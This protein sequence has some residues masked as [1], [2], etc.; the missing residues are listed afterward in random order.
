MQVLNTSTIYI[1]S[2]VCCHVRNSITEVNL[3]TTVYPMMNQFLPVNSDTN[4]TFNCSVQSHLAIV[5]SVNGTQISHDDQFVN[6]MNLGYAIEPMNTESSYS[7]MTVSA[8]DT[9]SVL[10]CLPFHNHIRWCQ[11][12]SEEYSVVTYGN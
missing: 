12:C 1:P 9:N 8:M 10:E 2:I 11:D 5:W 4:V 3:A 6:F 7:T